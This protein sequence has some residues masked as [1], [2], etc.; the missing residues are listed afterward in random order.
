MVHSP[1]PIEPPGT[2][3]R[4][5]DDP[6]LPAQRRAGLLALAVIAGLGLWTLRVFLPALGWAII[7]AISLW[8]WR[9][10][11]VALWPRGADFAWP[12]LFTLTVALFFVLPC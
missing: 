4:R 1:D 9:Q 5:S 2:F 10:R 12:A 8:P 3:T 7:L 6:W 11:A